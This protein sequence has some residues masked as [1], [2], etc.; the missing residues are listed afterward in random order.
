MNLYRKNINESLGFLGFR[1]HN[2]ENNPSGQWLQHKKEKPLIR[3]RICRKNW[4][5]YNSIGSLITDY[6]QQL[7]NEGR[8]F[9]FTRDTS[10]HWISKCWSPSC[11]SHKMHT[12]RILK[13]VN[14]SVAWKS[15]MFFQVFLKSTPSTLMLCFEAGNIVGSV[16][17]N[18]T[19]LWMY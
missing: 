9:R 16:S 10:T 5:L 14:P 11:I 4:K 12:S 17:I 13:R 7:L 2:D 3:V 6:L 18:M 15:V 8:K 1:T 19:D